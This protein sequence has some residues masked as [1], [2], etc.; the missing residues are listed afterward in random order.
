MGRRV[1]LKGGV[2]LETRLARARATKDLDV[3]LAGD[4]A[5]ARTELIAAAGRD[6]GD[7]FTFELHPKR[8]A[9]TVDGPSV[10]CGGARCTAAAFLNERP[11]GDPFG[12][13]TERGHVSRR[14]PCGDRDVI[15]LL[16]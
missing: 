4:V 3:S 2:V 13:N 7:R 5:T 12:I 15:V 16:P 14:R 1:L 11:F 6:A 10:L 9:P 8:G